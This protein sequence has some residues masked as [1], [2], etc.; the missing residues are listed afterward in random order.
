MKCELTLPESEHDVQLGVE[1]YAINEYGSVLLAE[2]DL[3]VGE[4]VALLH[5]SDLQ[6]HVGEEVI[7]LYSIFKKL[8]CI[9]L[10]FVY[11]IQ[12][13]WCIQKGHTKAFK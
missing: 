11:A 6:G 5:E 12:F 7:V 10:C 8:L 13:Y 2:E 3:V 1:W 9:S 4:T